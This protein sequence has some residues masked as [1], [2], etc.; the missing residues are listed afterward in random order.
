MMNLASQISTTRHARQRCQQR[1]IRPALLEA[2]I[3]HS[4]IERPA[5]GGAL[6]VSVSKAKAEK[7]N[8]DDRLRHCC[9]V[10]ADDGA[11]ITVAHFHGTRRGKSWRRGRR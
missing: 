4:D 11:V 8:L 9:V 6:M 5:G 1:G 3:T 10:L 7:L 2:V